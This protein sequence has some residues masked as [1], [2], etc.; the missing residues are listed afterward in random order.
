MARF[1]TAP[2]DLFGRGQETSAPNLSNGSSPT[3]GLG[4]A[5]AVSNR[6]G[7]PAWGFKSRDAVKTTF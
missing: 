7:L 1:G 6:F 3:Q 5:R 4:R 2:V